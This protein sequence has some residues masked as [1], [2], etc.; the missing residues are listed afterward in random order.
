MKAITLGWIAISSWGIVLILVSLCSSFIIYSELLTY[1]ETC[2]IGRCQAIESVDPNNKTGCKYKF[3]L[4]KD[5]YIINECPR[6]LDI[7]QSK[8][9]RPCMM[10]FSRSSNCPVNIC[11]HNNYTYTVSGTS[12]AI[13]MFWLF[14]IVTIIMIRQKYLR[15]VG[16]RPLYYD[17]A[18]VNE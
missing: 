7:C 5:K 18:F 6:S 8:K 13:L 11:R 2:V 3:F 10:D 16:Y 17:D 1:D 15:T 4:N 12:F 14:G 9:S